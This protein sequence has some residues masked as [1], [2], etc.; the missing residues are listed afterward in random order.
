MKLVLAVISVLLPLSALAAH[1]WTDVVGCYGT[2]S[3]NGKAVVTNGAQT[4]IKDVDDLAV[5]HD[6]KGGKLSGLEMMIVQGYNADTDEM[7][8]DYQAAVNNIG[9]YTTEGSKR[10]FAFAGLIRFQ[11]SPTPTFVKARVAVSWLANGNLQLETKREVPGTGGA[12][13][14]NDI[15][16]LQKA[17]CQ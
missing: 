4:S 14:T 13:D 1:P 10:V 5:I 17:V 9:S 2:V 11:D 15:Y 6:A 12:Y 8:I 3:D 16:V 7:K